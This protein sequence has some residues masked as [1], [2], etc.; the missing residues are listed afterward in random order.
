MRILGLDIG[1][2]RIGLAI[3]DPSGMLATPKGFIRRSRPETDI[4][5]ISEIAEQEGAQH[6]VA[7]M[8]LSLSGKMGPQAKRVDAFVEALRQQ[9]SIPVDVWDERYSTV[10]A[11]HLLRQAGR[12]PSRERGR[13]DAAAAAIILQGYLDSKRNT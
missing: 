4:A 1:E 8:P 2:R 11:E 10:D 13:V 9:S 3:S 7:G 6:I 12:K 5:K